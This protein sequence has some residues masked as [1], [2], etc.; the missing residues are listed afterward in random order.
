MK[1]SLCALALALAPVAA[2]ASALP[3]LSFELND[4]SVVTL[5]SE[6]LFLAFDS[7]FMRVSHSGGSLD[8]ALDRLTKF[9]FDG[10]FS[11]ISSVEAD[12]P[13]R[14]KIFS[15]TGVFRGEYDSLESA[16]TA[17]PAG[18]YVVKTDLRTF[19]TIVK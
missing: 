6:G 18:I 1:H 5:P 11:A 10:D 15:V 14:V 8:I 12:E 19:K 16:R 2:S 13:E 17:L 4:G 7:N 3:T 9:Y